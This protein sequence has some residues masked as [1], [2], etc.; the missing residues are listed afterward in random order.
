MFFIFSRE[1]SCIFEICDYTNIYITI[2]Y[3][4]INPESWGWGGGEERE[5]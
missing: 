5:I 1:I 4:N 2:L 3:L